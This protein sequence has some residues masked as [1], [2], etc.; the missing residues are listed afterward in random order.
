M[1]PKK[2]LASKKQRL[3][4]S[5]VDHEEL[6]ASTHVPSATTT[7]STST[8]QIPTPTPQGSSTPTPT[9]NQITTPTPQ[10]TST[11]TTQVP[12]AMSESNSDSDSDLRDNDGN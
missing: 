10:G 8:P 2:A 9:P 12:T 11:P 5:S 3:T 7:P 4:R 1:A 6:S